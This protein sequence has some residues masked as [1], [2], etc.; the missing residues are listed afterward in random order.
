VHASL[1]LKPSLR[2][3]VAQR[4]TLASWVAAGSL[5]SAKAAGREHRLLAGTA[6]ST[7]YRD[8]ARAAASSRLPLD[9][10]SC[11]GDG[12]VQALHERRL[13]TGLTMLAVTSKAF[14]GRA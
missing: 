14:A 9:S 4:A 12:C 3:R 5:D 11:G 7:L 13:V 2:S 8:S 1:A 10:K 6:C